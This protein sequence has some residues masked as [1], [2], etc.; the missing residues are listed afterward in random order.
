MSFRAVP[1]GAV[2]V[3]LTLTAC[4]QVSPPAAPS[5]TS[6]PPAGTASPAVPT[7][8]SN[9]TI[10]SVTLTALTDCTFAP[11]GSITSGSRS[12]NAVNGLPPKFAGTVELLRIKP[13]HS[14]DDLR[15]HI[16]EE[17]RRSQAGEPA[18]GPPDWTETPLQVEVHYSENKV[19]SGT[20]IE[21][22]YGIVCTVANGVDF[23]PVKVLGPIAVNGSAP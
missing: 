6:T 19:V 20:L 10:G 22:T 17:V 21:G 12:L 14:F 13:G 7:S 15:S 8:D 5:A 3:L 11:S 23:R 4:G 2:T 1:A 16:A 9:P 18:L